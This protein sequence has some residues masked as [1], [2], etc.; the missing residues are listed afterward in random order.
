MLLINVIRLL[1]LQTYSGLLLATIFYDYSVNED[2]SKPIIWSEASIRKVTEIETQYV[3]T[4]VPKTIC[5]C[6]L[7]MDPKFLDS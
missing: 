1:G 5:R 4:S 2:V 7:A 3:I 6:E